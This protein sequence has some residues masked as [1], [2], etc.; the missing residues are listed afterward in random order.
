MAKVN[1]RNFAVY[2]DGTKVADS[3]SCTLNVNAKL[4]E[5]TSQDSGTSTNRE[6]LGYDWSV[7]AN[8]HWDE[9][10]SWS[11]VDA[12]DGVLAGTQFLVEF[13]SAGSSNTYYYGYAYIDSTSINA[14]TG[15][16]VN[17]PISWQADGDLTKASYSGS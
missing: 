1:G 14:D 4:A 2:V 11:M 8:V 10:N 6:S 5:V 15:S 13:S 9:S 16:F 17:G 3:T 12:V 7:S